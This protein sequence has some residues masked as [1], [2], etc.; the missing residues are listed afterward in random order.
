M[1]EVLGEGP[2]LLRRLHEPL[3]DRIRVDLEHPCG[4]PDAHAFGQA[5]DD[6][7]DEVDGG[8]LTMKDGAKGFEKI[9]ATHDAQQL[10]PG[11]AVGMAV[12]AEIA[13]A[14]PALIRTVRVRAEMHRGIHLAAAP[15]CGHNTRGPGAWCRWTEGAGTPTRD[16]LRL[17]AAGGKG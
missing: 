2:Q 9:A 13:P 3:Q 6:A 5:R 1:Q 4:A 12:G 15:P 11:T 17:G 8:A 14:D 7:H 16:A 10:A